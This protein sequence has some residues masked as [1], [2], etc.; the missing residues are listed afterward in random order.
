MPLLAFFLAFVNYQ[1]IITGLNFTG[2]FCFGFHYI[3]LIGRVTSNLSAP[4]V[5]FPVF[6]LCQPACPIAI[7]LL[8]SIKP[9]FVFHVALLLVL[10]SNHREHD[11]ISLYNN[12]CPGE[13]LD[14]KSYLTFINHL[15]SVSRKIYII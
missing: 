5:S 13:M 6:W 15:T 12:P 2:D 8:Y 4:P 7:S 14:L 10:A 11:I 1:W 9:M 3:A